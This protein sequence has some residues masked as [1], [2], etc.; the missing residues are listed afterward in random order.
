MMLYRTDIDGLRAVAILP[1]VLYHAGVPHFAGGFVGVD[2]FFVI[3]GYLITS[4]IVSDIALGRFSILDFYQR[5]AWRILPPLFVMMVFCAVC[6]LVIYAPDDLKRLGRAT[7]ATTLFSSNILFWR[8]SSYFDRQSDELPLLHT[9]SLAVEEQFYATYPLYLILIRRL[10]RPWRNTVTLA[11]CLASF[12]LSVWLARVSEGASFYLAP[13]RAWELLLGGLLAFGLFPDLTSPRSRQFAGAM[14]LTI[15]TAA[16]ACYSEH[17]PYA[18]FA[19]LLPTTGALC[20]IWAG[21]RR[22]STVNAWLSRPAVVFIGKISY[23]LYLWHFPLLAF[24]SYLSITPPSPLVRAAIVALSLALALVSWLLVE[25]PLRRPR[26]GVASRLL[27][28]V[29]LAV[30]MLLLGAFGV[31]VD[32][33]QGFPGR[34]SAESRATIVEADDFDPDRVACAVNPP[35]VPALD[36]CRLGAFAEQ[37]PQFV[38]WGDSHAEAWR[39][40]VDDVARKSGASGI[41]LGRVACAPLIGVERVDEPECTAVN[42][43]IIQFI[44]SQASIHTVLLAAR[45]GFWSE[46]SRYKSELRNPRTISLLLPGEPMLGPIENR[47]IM[48]AGLRGTVET[49]RSSDKEVWLV[50]PLPEIGYPVPKSLYL[51]QLGLDRDFD[52]R[53]TRDEF[54][55][56][57]DFVIGLFNQLQREVG[58]RTVWPHRALCGSGLC[59][60]EGGD[61]PYYVD[62]NHLSVFGAKALESVFTP[63]F[64]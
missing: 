37:A 21:N 45:W 1:V 12:T 22:G 36:R 51:Q 33:G 26:A 6:G 27:F 59:Q 15:I 42:D 23:S 8:S 57:Q 20:V 9:W 63:V 39:P 58:I 56:R 16:V 13:S 35:L 52:I 34:L 60:V 7:L 24:A 40:A 25:Q 38:L 50:G 47:P 14:G 48:A 10:E 18:G 17:T 3:S 11:L 28:P 32:R 4:L 31:A 29:P 19:G 46:G 53:P 55:A 44:R 2:V 43:H 41:F 49:L 64:E 54:F 61:Q 30:V 5:R 62:D